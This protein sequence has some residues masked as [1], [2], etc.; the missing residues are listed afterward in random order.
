MRKHAK[1]SDSTSPRKS[2]KK[3]ETVVSGKHSSVGNSADSESN[4]SGDR[5]SSDGGV[6]SDEEAEERMSGVEEEEDIVD[7]GTVAVEREESIDEPSIDELVSIADKPAG[8]ASGGDDATPT[9]TPL[10][11]SKPGNTAGKKKVHRQLPEWILNFDVIEN[12]IEK[13]SE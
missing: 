4:V 6:S 11:R 9:L 8:S 1:L 10:G 13:Y 2:G 5:L 12:D 3:T 7:H